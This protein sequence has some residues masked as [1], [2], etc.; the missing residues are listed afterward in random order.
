MVTYMLIELVVML[1]ETGR[2]A[3]DRRR[4][5]TF[6]VAELLHVIFILITE[7]RSP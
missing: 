1:E 4:S 6:I 3:V 2:D 5:A 7:T